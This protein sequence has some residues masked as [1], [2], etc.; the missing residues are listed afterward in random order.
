MLRKV[1]YVTKDEAV[2]HGISFNDDPNSAFQSS[3]EVTVDGRSNEADFAR[4]TFLNSCPRFGTGRYNI[5]GYT[6]EVKC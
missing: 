3:D 1:V 4:W 5:V 2:A 6:Q